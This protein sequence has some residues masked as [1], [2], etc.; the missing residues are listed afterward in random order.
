MSKTKTVRC[1]FFRF[2]RKHNSLV[3]FLLNFG[4]FENLIFLRINLNYNYVLC[5]FLLQFYP[6]RPC[7][8]FFLA[9]HHITYSIYLLLFW[10]NLTFIIYGTYPTICRVG[11]STIC[12]NVMSLPFTCPP[13]CSSLKF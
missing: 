4:H 3:S 6:N 9:D 8:K 7:S 11:S 10:K 2:L 13:S 5:I 12:P 1:V